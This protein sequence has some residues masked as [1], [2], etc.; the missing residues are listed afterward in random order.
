[1]GIAVLVFLL[2]AAWL[3]SYWHFRNERLFLESIA[4]AAALESSLTPGNTDAALQIGNLAQSFQRTITVFDTQGRIMIDSEGRRSVD[5]EPTGSRDFSQAI[6][7]K[8]GHALRWNAVTAR[9]EIMVAAPAF[10]DEGRIVRVVRA[11]QPVNALYASIASDLLPLAIGGLLALAIASI[12]SAISSKRF[13]Q[14][15]EQMRRDAER[16]GRGELTRALPPS[17]RD[18]LRSLANTLNTMAKQLNQRIAEL[19]R[20]R[21]ERIA[22][23]ESLREGVVAIDHAERVLNL[24]HAAEQMLG[25]EKNTVRGLLVQEAIRNT[26]IHRFLRS[27][28]RGDPGATDEGVML[29]IRGRT[30]LDIRSAP[31]LDEDGG[32]LGVLLIMTNV[33]RLHEL[34]NIR[35]E[36]V[37]NV[38]HELRTP[39]TSISGFAETL[40]DSALDD[41]EQSR[42]FV[43]IIAR[44]AQR[45]GA[46][47]DD[48]LS[49]S[50]LDRAHRPEIEPSRVSDILASALETQAPRAHENSTEVVVD[51]DEALEANVNAGLIER[52]VANLIE[53]AIKYSG[54]GARVVVRARREDQHLHITVTDNG[55]GIAAEHLPR[56]FERFY[57]A[58]KAR[59]RDL[60]G[61]G[62]GLSIVKNIATAHGGTVEV[63]TTPGAGSTFRMILPIDPTAK[64]PTPSDRQVM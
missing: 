31:L 49:L 27:A 56:L 5:T 15:I 7:G 26:E 30:L 34:E 52:A 64:A 22:I 20:E 35:R 13:S 14:P 45:L 12:S 51:C 32:S 61:T 57:R 60:G 1:V 48:L 58:D 43:E 6:T 42:H 11:S 3:V 62:L 2:G 54:F 17:P 28:L 24:N 63:D 47:I 10:D 21:N 19:T 46:T 41:P 25:I 16:F 9:R 40:L 33:T 39:I 4:D 50:R 59:S 37:A 38:S 36:F 8:V 44:Q 29:T 55:P 53:N 23:L 18:D